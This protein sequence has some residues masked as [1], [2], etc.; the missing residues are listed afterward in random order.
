MRVYYSQEIQFFIV[1]WHLLTYTFIFHNNMTGVYDS[2]CTK[3]VTYAWGQEINAPFSKWQ[4]QSLS[5]FRN[6]DLLL[7][8]LS[9]VR[10]LIFQAMLFKKVSKSFEMLFYSRIIVCFFLKRTW[11]FVACLKNITK[12]NMAAPMM[13][14]HGT[15]FGF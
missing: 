13:G 1:N 10:L 15:F 2:F 9:V 5:V 14:K 12:F 11:K 7:L 3:Y 6:F 4:A 8:A